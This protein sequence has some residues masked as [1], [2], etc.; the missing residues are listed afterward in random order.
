MSNLS[1]HFKSLNNFE[2]KQAFYGACSNNRVDDI[3]Y[4]LSV[5]AITE[6][7]LSSEEDFG[8]R[9]ACTYGA[10]DVIKY[11]MSSDDIFN[12]HNIHAKKDSAFKS[13]AR[14]E[15]FAVIEY[16]I[17]ELNIKKTAN[18]ENYLLKNPNKTIENIFQVRELNKQ[19]SFNFEDSPLKIKI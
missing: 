6:K 12:R 15:Q 10:I 2:I 19:L 1:E 3:K 14:M 9:C 17:L 16:L 8:L 4:L 5:N 7:D 11:F 13:A 18:I